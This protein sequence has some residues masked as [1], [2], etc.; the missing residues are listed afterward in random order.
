MSMLSTRQSL[1]S[2][3][4]RF[5]DTSLAYVDAIDTSAT[6]VDKIP[7]NR[8]K[9]FKLQGCKLLQLASKRLV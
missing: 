4:L 3:F 5:I 6:Y 7:D 1:V 8:H 2:I 9:K